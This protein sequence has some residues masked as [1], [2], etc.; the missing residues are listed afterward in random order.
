[1]EHNKQNKKLVPF[2]IEHLSKCWLGNRQFN[3]KLPD[4][5]NSRDALFFLYGRNA[6]YAILSILKK[7]RGYK[8]ILFGAYSCGD[9]IQPAVTLGYNVN[10][11]KLSQEKGLQIDTEDLLKLLKGFRGVLIITHY[12]GFV[13]KDINIIAEYCKKNDIVLVENCAHCLGTRYLDR[14]IGTFGDYSIF[15]LRKNIPLPHGGV[16]VANNKSI[17]SNL[18]GK[19]KK[20]FVRPS[21]M[22]VMFDFSIFLSY[23]SGFLCKGV[24]IEKTLKNFSVNQ[25]LHGPRLSVYGGYK[26]RLSYLAEA[27][28]FCMNWEDKMK[29]KKKNFQ[30][31]LSYFKKNN[32]NNFIVV[33]KILSHEYPMFFPVYVKNSESFFKKIK[34]YNIPGVQPFWSHRHNFVNWKLFAKEYTLK[35][36][37]LALPTSCFIGRE[38]LKII[39]K[40]LHSL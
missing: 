24:N 27:I 34:R 13:Q 5:L 36:S 18:E 12:L 25:S 28:I 40:E 37:I 38:N 17:V 32:M 2:E 21:S 20:D 10:F 39:F 3:A 26:L 7:E 31:Y 19:L 11:F 6:L 16:L 29:T 8:K 9:E 33:E 4:P 15:S 14:A 23:Q 35:N 1:M 22:A 30:Q